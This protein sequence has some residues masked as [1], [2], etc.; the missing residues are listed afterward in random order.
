MKKSILKKIV[1]AAMAMSMIIGGSAVS[2]A[3]ENDMVK[4]DGQVSASQVKA[5]GSEITPQDRQHPRKTKKIN[6]VKSTEWSSFKRVS[7]NMT[8]GKAGGTIHCQ[9]SVSFGTVVSGTISGLGISTSATKSTTVGYSINAAPNSTSYM[10]YRVKYN[11]E[12]GTRVVYDAVTG[13]TI[14]TN[15]YTVKKPSIGE[16]KLIK[17][18]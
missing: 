13:K 4:T 8:V 16:Y 7:D 5:N 18:K 12:K 10:A 14:S 1:I 2:F 17:V 11:V 3:G 9:K 15:K 6:V